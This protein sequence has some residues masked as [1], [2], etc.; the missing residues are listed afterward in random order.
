ML[1]SVL[2]AALTAAAPATDTEGDEA[3]MRSYLSAILARDTAFLKANS[4]PQVA[5]DR[6]FRARQ[7]PSNLEDSVE[8]MLEKTRD[9]DVGAL[10]R[11][12][13]SQGYTV[14]WWCSYYDEPA[15]APFQG[16]G[17]TLRVR[18]GLV[19]IGNFSWSGP[20]PAWTPR[21]VGR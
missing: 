6:D 11:D 12:R 4:H 8:A 1:G 14:N 3:L 9:C 16:A 2:A 21:R 20:Y 15:G 10:M 19:E 17:A 5:Y 13:G 18:D 7:T